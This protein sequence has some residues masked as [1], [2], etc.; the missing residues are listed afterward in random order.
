MWEWLVPV[1]LIVGWFVVVR[2]GLPALG[3]PT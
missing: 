2:W 3:V 1:A